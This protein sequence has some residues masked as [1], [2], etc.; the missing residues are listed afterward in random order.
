[1]GI[2][3]FILLYLL[4]GI[5]IS[6]ICTKFKILN[7]VCNDPVF[8]GLIVIGWIM[9]LPV[10]LMFIVLPTFAYIVDKVLMIF[11]GNK[12]GE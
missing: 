6:A 5:V 4:I 1:M 7:N 11:D 3:T 10:L 8:R 9:F 2:S 12:K